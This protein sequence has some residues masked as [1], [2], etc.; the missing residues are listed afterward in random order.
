MTQFYLSYFGGGQFLGRIL[1][2]TAY[3]HFEELEESE[4]EHKLLSV[5]C[6]RQL[7]MGSPPSIRSHHEKMI[8][9]FKS[10]IKRKS[11]N[12]NNYQPPSAMTQECFKDAHN[13]CSSSTT[14][15]HLSQFYGGTP[16]TN[17]PSTTLMT[18]TL[19]TKKIGHFKCI[20]LECLLHDF[21]WGVCTG[22][23]GRQVLLVVTWNLPFCSLA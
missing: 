19:K 9:S 23:L 7:S 17:D 16:Y 12:Q 21:F 14:V 13:D 20:D 11:V 4:R 8:P 3:T 22:F 18:I 10:Q 2:K 1:Q 15:P 5:C 6:K